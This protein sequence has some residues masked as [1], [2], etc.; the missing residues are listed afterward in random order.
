MGNFF[1]DDSVMIINFSKN[2]FIYMTVSVFRVL[3]VLCF[4]AFGLNTKQIS[5]FSPNTWN[6]RPKN[7]E[8][9]HFLRRVKDVK[10][11]LW[12]IIK[13]KLLF[14][15]KYNRFFF[16]FFFFL[17]ESFKVMYCS[18]ENFLLRISTVNVTLSV[19]SYGIKQIY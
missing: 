7:S 13:L 5:L 11:S 9:G 12:L 10:Q 16:F 1:I 19:V 2:S 8:Y 17:S 15:G 18:V 6:H 4:P 14:C 3:L